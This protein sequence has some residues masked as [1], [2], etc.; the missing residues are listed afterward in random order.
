MKKTFVY[1]ELIEKISK[2]NIY[3]VGEEV[4][5]E[6]DGRQLS[7][8]KVS[9]RYEIFDF[10]PFVIN[11]IDEIVKLY[12]IEHYRLILVK[13]IQEIRLYSKPIIIEGEVFRR[14]FYLLNS[15]DKSRALSFSY[16]LSHNHFDFIL[17]GGSI[18][19]K[20]YRGIT[21]YVE[22]RVDMD[23]TFFQNQIEILKKI[24]GDKILMSNVQKIVTE[25]EILADSKKTLKTNFDNLR[26]ML[27]RGTANTLSDENRSKLFSYV[28]N[29][30]V[31][32]FSDSTVDFS[33]DSFTVLKTYLRMFNWSDCSTIRRESERISNLSILQNRNLFIDELLE[34]N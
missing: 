30:M 11:C 18:T 15:S 2:I 20:H 26:Y 9:K 24:I 25:S 10:K 7:S 3:L 6:F 28:R 5:T 32:D 13:G 4:I 1:N 8:T 34:E 31:E 33:I 12:E 27:Y 22:E 14:T 16:G 17:K 19:K 21:E 23:D 29:N